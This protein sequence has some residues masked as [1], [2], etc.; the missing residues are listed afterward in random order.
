[1][2][3]Y[4]QMVRQVMSRFLKVNVV[5]MARGQNQH[6]NSLATL[7]SSMIEEVPR[8]IKVELMAEPSI[9][10]M[11]GVLVVVMSEPC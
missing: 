2:K 8:I 4:L 9:N 1:M 5:Q 3:K 11:V 6:A 7:A 10:I